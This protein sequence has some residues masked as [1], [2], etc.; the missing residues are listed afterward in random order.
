MNPFV[1][2]QYGPQHTAQQP[3]PEPM[4]I[5]SQHRAG[6]ETNRFW[7]KRAFSEQVRPGSAQRPMK[8]QRLFHI[9]EDLGSDNHRSIQ[10][11]DEEINFMTLASP[12]YL[13]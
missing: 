12:A 11:T 5:D 4:E 1:N 3:G 13:T 10:T 2:R 9:E 8:Q 7:K 6:S